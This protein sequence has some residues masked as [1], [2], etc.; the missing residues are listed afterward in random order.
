[1]LNNNNYTCSQSPPSQ[2]SQAAPSF[3]SNC[4]THPLLAFPPPCSSIQCYF[5]L[6]TVLDIYTIRYTFSILLHPP[7][8]Q[9]PYPPPTLTPIPLPHHS[10]FKF[11]HSTALFNFTIFHSIS[12]KLYFHSLLPRILHTP[13]SPT[14]SVPAVL[15]HTYMSLPP[16]LGC[17]VQLY[18]NIS[19]NIL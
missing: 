3:Q 7:L 14:C 8:H 4:S 19:F 9:I 15:A 10:S 11:P 1:M 12:S 13:L 18:T 2:P 5:L 16:S 6:L 17:S